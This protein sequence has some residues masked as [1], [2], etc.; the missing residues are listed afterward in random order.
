MIPIT[1][2]RGRDVAVVGLARSGLA[3]ARALQA[4]GAR[5]AAWDDS[6]AKRASVGL[7]MVDPQTADWQSFAA[8]VLSPGIPLTHPAPHP[9]VLR[10]ADAQVDVIG[11][12]ELL[13][14]EGLDAMLVGVTGT[15]GKSTTTA[16]I[17]HVLAAA[18]RRVQVGG[19]IGAPVLDLDPLGRG[20]V[21]VVELSSF[22]ID[23]TPSLNCEVAILLN[24]TPDHLDRH[25]DMAGYVA[26]KRRIFDRV[27]GVAV[28]GVDDEWGRQI[29]AELM[30]ANRSRNVASSVHICTSRIPGLS[31]RTPPPGRTISSRAVVLCRPFPVV[32]LTSS[33]HW[34]S[35]PS[36]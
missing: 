7:P 13:L 16:L 36:R 26:V 34:N 31:M 19:N 3:A 28:I 9:V 21:Y 18:G 23:L 24:I 30:S 29:A 27:K 5:V 25:G 1:A 4:G 11:D 33:V 35:S 10:A 6:A 8:V 17:G 22:Q 14:R 32:S 20:G 15:N 12:I 2:F